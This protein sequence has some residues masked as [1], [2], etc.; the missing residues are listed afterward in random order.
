MLTSYL[1]LIA[2]FV[3]GVCL[4][5]SQPALPPLWPALCLP[6]CFFVLSHWYFRKILS[7]FIALTIGFSWASWHAHSRMADRLNPELEQQ[8]IEIKGLIT[9]LPQSTRFGTRFLFIPDP[10]PRQRLPRK[11]QLQWY[12]LPDRVNAGERWHFLV[13]LKQVHG[14]SNPG[15]FDLESWFLQQGIGATG[16]V[17]SGTLL[18]GQGAWLHRIRAHLRTHILHALPDAPY[19]GVMIALTVG[20]QGAIL[21]EQWQRFAA[22][23][24]TH[25]ISISGLHITLLAAIAAAICSWIWRRLPYLAAR[26]A[27]QR[28]ALIAGVIT[29]FCYCLLAGMAVPTQRTLF[30]LAITAACLWR[31]Q[32][33]ALSAIWATALL[34]TVIIDPFAVLSIGFWL[35]Y[36][37]VGALLWA[38]SNQLGMETKW[39]TW[40]SAQTTATLASAPILLVI[41]GQLPLVSPLANAFAIPI[42]SIFVTPL[43]LAGLLDPS[44]YLLYGAERLFAATDYL[45]KWCATLPGLTFNMPNTLTLLPAAFGV[46]LLLLPRGMPARYLGIIC[47]LPLFISSPNSVL[48]GQYRVTVLDVGQGLAV[49]VQTT[50]HRLLFDTGQLPNG[51]RVLLPA[52]RS[53]Q[54]HQLDGLILS[55]NDQDHIGAAVPLLSNIPTNIIWHSLPDKHLL[56]EQHPTDKFPR[57][58]CQTGK[59]WLWD[60]VRF[61]LIWPDPQFRGNT[62]NAKGCVLLVDN[63]LHKLLIPADIGVH[64][65]ARLIEQGLGKIDILLVPHHGSKTSSSLQ[66]V[67]QTMPQYAIFS[68][69]Y[70]NRFGHP[71]PEIIARYAAA[72]AQN[73]RTDQSGALIF[74]VGQEIKL[75]SWRQNSPHYWSTDAKVVTDIASYLSPRIKPLSQAPR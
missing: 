53:S 12:G 69:G 65:E 74:D 19:R 11:I 32:P 13:K 34:V 18:P 36:L 59:T 61:S 73:L 14:Q 52:L 46:M 41:F 4:L 40:I 1:F 63:G 67:E 37:T 21:Q 68:V 75:S 9:D 72:Q 25:L 8:V 47:C 48:Q 38:G 17:K 5:Q 54:I 50:N 35:S 15:S 16:T 10:A 28:A 33:S 71:K 20:D 51:D 56:W 57:Q 22:T 26:F 31:T 45:L 29:A 24:I 39:K 6:I 30:M 7:V 27:A 64:E 3:C 42:V 43:A 60:Q 66:F 23:G 55:H 49:L 44:G 2:G 70:L 62:D 58:A